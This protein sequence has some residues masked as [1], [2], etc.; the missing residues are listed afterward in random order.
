MVAFSSLLLAG[1]AVAGVLGAPRLDLGQK[2][3]KRAS[4]TP[5]SEGLGGDGFFYS[6][7][8][9]EVDEMNFSNGAAG[10]YSLTWSGDGDVVC[11][12]GW[13]TGSDR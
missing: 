12:K 4:F 8:S 2:L 13:Q 6:I 7:W 11:G 3:S 9:N 1:T 5:S 10:E